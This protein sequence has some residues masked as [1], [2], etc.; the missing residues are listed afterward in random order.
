[1]SAAPRGA[2]CAADA[3]LPHTRGYPQLVWYAGESAAAGGGDDDAVIAR[4]DTLLAAGANV[5]IQAMNGATAL[6]RAAARGRVAVV[7]HLLRQPGIDPSLLDV[8]DSTPLMYAC[9]RGRL[10]VA[11][12]LLE[13]VSRVGDVDVKGNTALHALAASKDVDSAANAVSLAALLVEVGI[14]VMHRNSA[15]KLAS[16]VA[17]SPT[18]ADFLKGIQW[19]G[20]TPL[21]PLHAA[22]F[23]GDAACLRSLLDHHFDLYAVDD[24]GNTAMHAAVVGNRADLDAMLAGARS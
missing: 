5:N 15:G 3:P 12:L 14:N 23:N 13:T 6:H 4:L 19:R 8:A 24:A 22:V 20:D 11:R 9:Q 16:D 10:D 18:L 2:A 21:P 17:T 7:R 1:M